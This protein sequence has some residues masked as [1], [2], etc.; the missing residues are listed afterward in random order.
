M[1]NI[2]RLKARIPEATEAEL[3]DVLES[4][5]DVI[6]SRRF[7]NLAKATDEEKAEALSVHNEKVLEAAVVIYNMRGIEGQISH[8]ENGV[9][10]SYEECAGMKSILEKIIPRCDVV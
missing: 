3:E 2:E 8:S 4:A 1:T 10:R 5:K 6:L 9:A 7:V